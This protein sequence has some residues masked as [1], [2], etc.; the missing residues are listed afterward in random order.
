MIVYIYGGVSSGKSEYAEELISKSFENKIY[1]ATMENIGSYA[2]Q[3]IQ[4]HLKQ[5]ADK[6]FLTVEEPK[7]LSNVNISCVDNILL[8]DLTNL[9]S[10]NIFDE[11][12]MKSDSKEITEA[13]FS[14]I[15]ELEKRC[16]SLFIVGND[17]FSTKRNQSKELD[18]FIDCLFSLHQKIIDIAN[19]VVEVIYGLPYDR[20]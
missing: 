1:L 4:K 15:I 10:N 2:K 20:K 18:M 12:G 19:R 9:L 5:R 14:D 13:I 17:I 3:R 6:N 7:Y 8:E 11:N 16:N